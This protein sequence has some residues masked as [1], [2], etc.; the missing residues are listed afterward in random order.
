[1][2]KNVVILTAICAKTALNKKSRKSRKP[3]EATLSMTIAPEIG[4][5]DPLDN[6]AFASL[7]SVPQPVKTYHLFDAER[8]SNPLEF[9][10]QHTQLCS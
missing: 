5:E 10:F 7:V 8:R 4:F 6:E 2:L 3:V 9:D 1:M